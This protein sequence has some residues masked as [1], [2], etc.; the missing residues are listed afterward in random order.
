MHSDPESPVSLFGF[1]AKNEK[2]IHIAVPAGCTID[3]VNYF[4]NDHLTPMVPPNKRGRETEDII[5]RK[6]TVPPAIHILMLYQLAYG[7]HMMK[8]S[9]THL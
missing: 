5:K 4:G 9:G 3:A 1:F 2:S 7:Y 6:L 8:M